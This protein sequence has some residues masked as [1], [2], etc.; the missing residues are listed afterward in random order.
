[1]QNNQSQGPRQS[2]CRPRLTL[3]IPRLYKFCAPRKSYVLMQKLYYVSQSYV[4]TKLTFGFSKSFFFYKICS[5]HLTI[6][7]IS[8][9]L[10]CFKGNFCSF[11][12]KEIPFNLKGK[13]DFLFQFPV[14]VSSFF[15]MFKFARFSFISSENHSIPR[16]CTCSIQL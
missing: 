13:N 2:Q 7:S 3:G 10:N 5:F 8:S 12:K 4:S 6:S 16:N 1:M 14:L 15:K 9:S 11:N